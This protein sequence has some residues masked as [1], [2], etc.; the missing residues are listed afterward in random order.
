MKEIDLKGEFIVLGFGQKSRK[1]DSQMHNNEFSCF[2][3]TAESE[4][5]F[6]KDYIYD[7]IGK[8][9]VRYM[10]SVC[11]DI[12]INGIQLEKENTNAV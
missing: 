1:Q 9:S 4:L 12:T 2:Q 3:G 8:S 10:L 11:H 7:G 5:C 6:D